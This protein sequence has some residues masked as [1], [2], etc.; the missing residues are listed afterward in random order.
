MTQKTQ[1]THSPN[2]AWSLNRRSFLKTA[3]AVSVASSVPFWMSCKTKLPK[4]TLTKKQ[5]QIL[6]IVQEFLFPNDG[7]GPSAKD[8]NAH[9]YFQWVL[10]EKGTDTEDKEY[11]MQGL[12][13]VEETSQEETNRVL[14]DLRPREQNDLLEYISTREW[15]ESWFSMMLT[16]IFEALFCDPVYGGNVD[17]QGWK[18]LEHNPGQPRPTEELKLGNFLNHVKSSHH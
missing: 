2:P 11:L 9:H 4:F 7:N 1:Y 3:M 15:G 8:L 12:D 16:I 10:W 17:E 13:W 14:T 6:L 5:T 18:W